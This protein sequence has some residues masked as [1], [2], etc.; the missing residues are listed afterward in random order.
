V[1]YLF[2]TGRP[3]FIYIFYFNII[4]KRILIKKYLNM[5]EVGIENEEAKKA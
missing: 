2:P 1:R 5:I 4:F 3:L